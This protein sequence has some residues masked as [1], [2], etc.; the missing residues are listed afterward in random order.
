VTARYGAWGAG[1]VVL[2]VLALGPQIFSDFFLS[3]VLTQAL[4]LGIA[5]AS[6]IFL[7]GYG[8]MV[9]LGQTALY[10]IAG[11]SLGNFVVADGGSKIGLDPW[12][13]AALGIAVATGIGLLMGAVASRSEG[14]YFLMI[15]LAF[16]V[17]TFYFWG[18]VT[19]LSGFGGLNDITAPGIV[20]TPSTDPDN[21]FYITL[22]VGLAVYALLRYLVR[23]PFGLT[24]QGIRD[25]PT[26]MRALGYNVALHRTLAFG[27]GAFVASLAGVLF[28]WWNTRIDPNSINIG[29]T[30][31]ILVIAVIGGLLRLEGAW[32]GAL[33]FVVLDTYT[34]D[35]DLIGE[36][37]NTL[38][39]AI[40]LVIVL[41][42]PG[43]LFG[44]WTMVREQ[45]ARAAGR[46]P[47]APGPPGPAA[48]EHA[49]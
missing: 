14:I 9:S 39:G 45:I 49:P 11:M 8:G 47:A 23:T 28:V 33:V 44:I 48:R 17:I 7:S 13:G 29:A 2:V 30:L 26:R 27:F 5:A 34:R 40:F 41:L 36:R 22:V 43:G 32:L 24:L 12:V 25:D 37:F 19:Q 20:S 4:I 3:A 35:T 1:A 46:R 15:T 16:A 18:Q 6:L 21:L 42:S 10:G 38:I 31:D